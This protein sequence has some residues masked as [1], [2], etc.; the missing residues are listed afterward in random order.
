MPARSRNSAWS[1]PAATALAVIEGSE[2]ALTPTEIA[3]RVLTPSATLT[4]ALDLLERRGWIERTTNPDDRR[5]TLVTVTE[6]GHEVA[7]RL[8]PGIR[9]IEAGIVST[10]TPRERAQ[11]LR[12]IAKVLARAAEI[13]DAPPTPLVGRRNRAV[14]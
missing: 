10:L 14:R 9:T 12:L 6:E 2:R 5:S 8:L 1:Q 3:D 13:A 4:A 7:D 11:M